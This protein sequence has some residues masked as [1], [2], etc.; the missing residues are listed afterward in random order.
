M[1]KVQKAFDSISLYICLYLPDVTDLGRLSVPLYFTMVELT[2]E[3]S[4]FSAFMYIRIYTQ[5]HSREA[6]VCMCVCVCV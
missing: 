6:C 1:K 2:Q 3:T 5:M 4:K